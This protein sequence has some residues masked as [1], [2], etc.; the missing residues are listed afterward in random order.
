MHNVSASTSSILLQ[1]LRKRFFW[2]GIALS[3]IAL[4]SAGLN[5]PLW[6][7]ELHT[8]WVVSG[9]RDLVQPRAEI[10]N[11]NPAYFSVLWWLTQ[12]Q[13]QSEWR[14]R[15]PSL[16]AW[17]AT[18]LLCVWCV[19]RGM[20]ATG[21]AAARSPQVGRVPVAAW[22]ALAIIGWLGLDRV[23]LFYATEARPY[24]WMQMCTL[25]GWMMVWR[26]VA[27]PSAGGGTP[28]SG[29]R[30]CLLAWCA[31]SLV[32]IHLHLTA[33]LPV[34]CQA[35][36]LTLYAARP[37]RAW[38]MR[39][40]VWG[41]IVGCA[42]GA[43]PIQGVAEA[44]WGRRGQW[45]AFAGSSSPRHLLDMF[46]LWQILLPIAA[47]RLV[48]H[49]RDSKRI[50]TVVPALGQQAWP[51][52]VWAI[53]GFLPL[54]LGW[55]V[56]WMDWAPLMHRRFL[57]A[58][59]VPCLL[60]AMQVW[61]GI[62]SAKW[63]GGAWLIACCLLV[64]TQGTIQMWRSGYVLGWQRGEDWPAA[65][66]LVGSSWHPGD[67]LYCWA[68]LIEAQRVGGPLSALEAE[69]FSLPLRGLYRVVPQ[70]LGRPVEP[71]PLLGDGA[72]WNSQLAIAAPPDS[73]IDRMDGRVWIVYRGRRQSLYN[74]LHRMNNAGLPW[75]KWEVVQPPRAFGKV[76]VVCLRRAAVR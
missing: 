65:A 45:A 10:G 52:T 62:R 23:Q 64:T 53:A 60:W 24:A 61:L 12:W 5:E 1:L 41:A 70:D 16:L 29:A 55:W 68:G 67:R 46:P 71:L 19:Q 18:L 51:H 28:I 25:I 76:A 30:W 74:Q 58:A 66:A 49:V 57:L 37:G 42:V 32:A 15:W 36:L 72:D 14:L 33:S 39:L 44:V 4:A 56:T 22:I 69:Y 73:A 3:P 38:S 43:A 34:A 13:G 9:A 20:D 21:Q 50:L 2:W 6:V 26:I 63:R 48:Q 75:P 7:D 11:Q 59:E 47:A 40:G 35:G 27:W 54:V 17:G 8:S 31:A